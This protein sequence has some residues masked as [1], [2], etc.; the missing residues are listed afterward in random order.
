MS[1]KRLLLKDKYPS[2]STY[3]KSMEAVAN[4]TEPDNLNG[5]ISV[6]D[7][8]MLAGSASR[9]IGA[10]AEFFVHLHPQCGRAVGGGAGRSLSMLAL[11]RG[12]LSPFVSDETK[13]ECQFGSQK[14]RRIITSPQAHGGTQTGELGPDAPQVMADV[15]QLRRP[16]WRT[17]PGRSARRHLSGHPA[18][19][20]AGI[21]PVIT[22]R[23]MWSKAAPSRSGCAGR[24]QPA[25]RRMP[26]KGKAP[27]V[28]DEPEAGLGRTFGSAPQL[29]P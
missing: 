26:T 21:L 27:P 10:K 29:K 19:Q 8:W 5:F 7:C 17:M 16:C 28:S 14:V 6:F 20:G 23:S 13:G 2:V 3:T 9:I 22:A 11:P 15:R 25:H 1:G 24:Y 18:R 12:N 4:R